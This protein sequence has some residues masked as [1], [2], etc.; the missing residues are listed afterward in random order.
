MFKKMLKIGLWV[1]ED[2]KTKKPK[3]IIKLDGE[4]KEY[5]PKILLQ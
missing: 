2:E 5:F 4:E 1:I 3:Y